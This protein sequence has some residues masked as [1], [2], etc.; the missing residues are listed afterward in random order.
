MSRTENRLKLL[1]ML[2]LM[3]IATC[4]YSQELFLK[5]VNISD[6]LLGYDNY[7]ILEDANGTIW[8]SSENGVVKLQGDSYKRFTSADGLL[9]NDVWRMANDPVGRIWLRSYAAGIQYI[10]RDKIYT[11]KNSKQYD[12]IQ[13]SGYHR[14]TCFFNLK[15]KGE[16]KRYFLDGDGTL[17]HYNR[18]KSLGYEVKG[19]FAKHG[20]LLLS[21]TENKLETNYYYWLK[22]GKIESTFS[23]LSNINS[24]EFID[25]SPIFRCS[26]GKM[27]GD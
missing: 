4:S 21:K 2:T 27:L 9:T 14:D 10:Y 6:G 12:E 1:V 11:V 15:I 18:F 17:K 22:T 3:S 16:Q 7:G 25:E 23:Q 13:Y 8:V 24:R 19:D 5:K 26:S 20:F